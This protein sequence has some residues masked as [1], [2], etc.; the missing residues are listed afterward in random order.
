MALDF[1]GS[2]DYVN[3]PASY[4]GT[5][6][7]SFWLKTTTEIGAALAFGTSASSSTLMYVAIGQ[8]IS[9]TLTNE[10]IT[11][12]TIS[13]TARIEGYTTATRTE[14][15]DGNWH[16]VAVVQETANASYKIYL[17]G[18]LKTTTVGDAT[19]TTFGIGVSGGDVIQFGSRR[20][21]AAQ[22]V[23]YTGQADDIRLYRRPL[24]PPEIRLLA[25]RRGIGLQSTP[26]H[27]DYLETR[28]KTY[29]VIVK[30]QQEHSSLSEGLV[31]AW[32]PSL[33]AT[34]YRLVDRSGYGNHGTLTNM[35]SDDWVVSGGAGALD[36]ESSKSQ[37][38]DC[39]SIQ[40]I[41]P[42]ATTKTILAWIYAKQVG[43]F[44]IASFRNG[45][46]QGWACFLSSTN[47]LT[48]Y[49]GLTSYNSTLNVGTNR[50]VAVGYILQGSTI[51][52]LLDR[53]EPQTFTGVSIDEGAGFLSIGAWDLGFNGSPNGQIDDVRIYDR[54]ITTNEFYQFASRRG[55]GLQPRPK[56]FTFYQFPS[57]SKRRRIL[58]GMT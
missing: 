7:I 3:V 38:I 36:F 12:A 47:N 30:S 4:Y 37:Y 39:G 41:K 51:T 58:T 49:T 16:H 1:D 57:G 45:G 50:W 14:L 43:V 19:L 56:Q 20:F 8:N 10:L 25:S 28:E 54:K 18:N 33:G 32:C 13:G 29:S 40:K 15:L 5:G 11:V 2:D 17:D 26:R 55:I 22:G 34:G 46:S 53:M 27:T 23:Y 52:M 9:G 21:Q 35:T 6:A 44:G 48:A 42:S 24:T 31:G